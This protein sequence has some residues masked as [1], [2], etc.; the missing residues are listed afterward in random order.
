MHHTID[1]VAPPAPGIELWPSTLRAGDRMHIAFRAPRIV[2]MMK[3]PTYE[4][5][6]LD[7][8]RRRVATLLRG[9]ARASAGGVCIDWDGRDD[10]GRTVTAGAYRLRVEGRP[11]LLLERTLHVEW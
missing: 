9:P 8:R 7:P 10:F 11:G 3:L 4:V 1:P 6:V 2:G 5:T